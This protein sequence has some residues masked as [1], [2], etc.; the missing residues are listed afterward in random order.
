MKAKVHTLSCV[1]DTNFSASQLHATGGLSTNNSRMTTS[2][3]PR[4]ISSKSTINES[5]RSRTGPMKNF[6]TTTIGSNRSLTS[7]SGVRKSRLNRRK[8]N[9]KNDEEIDQTYCSSELSNALRGR[10]GAS[11]KGKK[12]AEQLRKVRKVDILQIT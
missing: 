8:G 3:S 10:K 2:E 7:K 9:S 6:S 1:L 4:S 12:S 11:L 5:V